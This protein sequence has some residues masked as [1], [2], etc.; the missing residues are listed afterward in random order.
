MALFDFPRI[1]FKGEMDINVAT[2]NNAATFPLTIYDATRSRPFLPPRLYFSSKDII[3]GVP[4]PLE[5]DT[6]YDEVS[7]V[8]YLQVWPRNTS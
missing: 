6:D 4:S 7:G 8:S 1:H 3:Q 5:P 2:I